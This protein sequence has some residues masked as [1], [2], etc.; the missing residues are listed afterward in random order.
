MRKAPKIS[1][2]ILHP[3]NN[4]Q[5]VPLTLAIFDLSTISAIS[6]YFP[7]EKTTYSFLNLIN[8]WWLVVN[9]KERFHSI[10]VGNA[11]V[12][13]DGKINFLYIMSDWLT[14]WRDSAK[15]GLSKQTFNALISTN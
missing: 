7:E 5:S 2:Q 12:A 15:L 6:Q 1:Y 4:K 10:I 14:T 9:A 11:Q 8:S 3:G 13:G